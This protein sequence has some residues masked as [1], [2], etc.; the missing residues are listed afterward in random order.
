MGT[1]AIERIFALRQKLMPLIYG[2]Y[3]RNRPTLVVEH[4]VGYVW[5]N[6]KPGHA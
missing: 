6:A 5:R 3:P 4:L 2:S 1:P